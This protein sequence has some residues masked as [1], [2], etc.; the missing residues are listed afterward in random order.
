MVPGKKTEP[1][2]KLEQLNSSLKGALR[3][4]VS[5]FFGLNP[6]EVLVETSGVFKE[7]SQEGVDYCCRYFRNHGRQGNHFFISVVPNGDYDLVS[8][9]SSIRKRIYD[10][11]GRDSMRLRKLI[12]DSADF[13]AQSVGDTIQVMVPFSLGAIQR[14]YEDEDCDTLCEHIVGNVL[15]YV[16]ER[17]KQQ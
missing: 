4:V 17:T 5:D 1:D 14:M 9:I 16:S 2:R 3:K 7:V 10:F 12:G 6:R 15:E 13:K 8:G 11:S